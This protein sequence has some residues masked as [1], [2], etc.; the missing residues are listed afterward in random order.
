MLTASPTLRS[1]AARCRSQNSSLRRSHS[2]NNRFDSPARHRCGCFPDSPPRP[3]E[4]PPA[5]CSSS[6]ILRSMAQRNRA[7]PK[8]LRFVKA[9]K[10]QWSEMSNPGAERKRP[11]LVGVAREKVGCDRLP[12]VNVDEFRSTPRKLTKM[13]WQ[14]MSAPLQPQALLTHLNLRAYHLRLAVWP[15]TPPQGGVL[16]V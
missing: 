2:P 10:L 5:Q 1:K 4:C 14:R 12:I 11:V 7:K 16:R 9:Y 15:G 13:P 3:Q 6:P 8:G